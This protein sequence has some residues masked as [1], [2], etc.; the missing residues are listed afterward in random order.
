[1][2]RVLSLVNKM[3][4]TNCP[5]GTRRSHLIGV[6]A[7]C[8]AAPAVLDLMD[9]SPRFV[10]WVVQALACFW[11]DY[12]DS[13]RFGYS[14]C[15]DKVLAPSLTLY[16]IYLALVFRGPV[17][18]VALAVPTFACYFHA[19]ARRRRGDFDGYALFHSLWHVWGGAVAVATLRS[20]R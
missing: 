20:A 7:V 16:I 8:Y 3:S 14:H 15:F 11:S 17:F 18:V 5:W 1:M 9:G 6:S 4:Q 19:Q 13:G 2:G 12:V 10:V